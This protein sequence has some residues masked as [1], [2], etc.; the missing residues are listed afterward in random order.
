MRLTSATGPFD[1]GLAQALVAAIAERAERAA[2]TRASLQQSS[3]SQPPAESTATRARTSLIGG[4]DLP[5]GWVKARSA[6]PAGSVCSN[7][8]LRALGAKP[9]VVYGD[10][11]V[12]GSETE[13]STIDSIVYMF[14]TE[15]EARWGLES[16][17][18]EAYFAC[19]ASARG[20]TGVPGET[21]FRELASAGFGDRSR[22]GQL[23]AGSPD[24]ERV[25]ASK[26]WIQQ[27]TLVGGIG[28]AAPDGVDLDL[29]RDVAERMARRLAS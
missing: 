16:L 19:V 15:H 17:A 11:F 14:S 21:R 6:D 27:G 23:V 9:L 29:A 26:V 8:L 3:P 7:D 28:L 20:D 10:P 18:G 1:A 5:P 12:P 2:V 4:S 24:E 13:V 25:I 22:V